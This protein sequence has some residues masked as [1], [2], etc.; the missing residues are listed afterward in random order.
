[1]KTLNDGRKLVEKI[2]E[3]YKVRYANRRYEEYEKVLRTL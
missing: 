1:M 3:E 2:V